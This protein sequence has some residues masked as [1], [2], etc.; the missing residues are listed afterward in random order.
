VALQPLHAHA[1]PTPIPVPP[2]RV[3]ANL[4]VDAKGIPFVLRGVNMPGLESA[5]AAAQEAMTAHTFR[6]IQQRWN[7]NAVRLPV[8][9]TIWKRDG[10]AY[11]DR[12]AAIVAAA[13]SESLIVI[14]AAQE[15]NTTGLP[16]ADMPAFWRAAAQR[17]RDTPRLIF[18]LY[19]E[20]SSRRTRDW[21]I[22]LNGGAAGGDAVIGMQALADAIRGTGATQIVAAPAFDDAREFQGFTSSDA[23]RDAN[24]LYESHPTYDHGLTDDER[25]A[26]FGFMAGRYPVLAGSWGMTFGS[27]TPACRAIPRNLALANDL[28]YQNLAYFDRFNISWTVSDFRPGSLLT[29]FSDAPATQLTVLGTCDASSNPRLGIGQFILLFMTGDPN[30]FGSLDPTLI[31]SAASLS[32]GPIAPGELIA[33]YGQTIG[34]PDP[35]GPSFAAPDRVAIRNGELQVFFDDIPAPILFAWSF[36]VNVQAPYE[37]AGRTSTQV[38]LLY[39]DIP[40][41]PVAIPVVDAAPGVFTQAGFSDAAAL[42]QDGS[43]NSPSNPAERGSVVS[44]F[45]TGCG[46]TAPPS[47]T[48]GVASGPGAQAMPV[49]VRIAARPAEVLYA[50]PAPGFTGVTQINVR[51]PADVPIG[52]ASERTSVSVAVAGETSRAAV[53]WAK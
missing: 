25:Q 28:L 11:L 44:L 16:S 34:P 9:A 7:M 39:R 52:S 29:D 19:H 8:S 17:F 50:G 30:G 31:A 22:W 2:L 20:P 32:L 6:I 43:I 49:T 53:L 18:A 38:R 3:Q 36:Q 24:V 4:L 47:I 10:A 27:D 35:T 21:Q 40:S 5:D 26:N 13:N 41:N 37:L 46:E 15:T 14:L 1:P 48:G 23:I 33:I 51:I 45:T 42:N 12:V